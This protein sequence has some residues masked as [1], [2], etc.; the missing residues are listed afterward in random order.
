MVNNNSAYR[1]DH[2]QLPRAEHAS[3]AAA[4]IPA[5]A[6]PSRW[7]MAAQGRPGRTGDMGSW[8][9]EAVRSVVVDRVGCLV[10]IKTLAELAEPDEASLVIRPLGIDPARVAEVSSTGRTSSPTSSWLVWC[11]RPRGL[12]MT[13]RAIYSYGVFCYDL[14]TVAGN[15]ARLVAEQ[16]LRSSSCHYDGTVIFVDRQDCDHEL[17]PARFSDLFDRDNPLVRRDWRLKLRSGRCIA[18]NGML[19]SLL[20]W[21]REERLLGGQRDR[22]RDRFRITFRNYVAHSEYHREMPDDAAAEIF[23]LSEL[24]NQLWETGWHGGTQ[25]DRS[26]RLDGYKRHV[27]VR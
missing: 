24:I 23:H 16:A 7:D 9:V 26:A 20:R 5:R 11:L 22:W 12:A 3:H 13:V 21:A 4:G 14:Y 10:I 2:E 18:F 6:T 17:A 25:G 8:A 19:T 27:R 15:Q 1:A